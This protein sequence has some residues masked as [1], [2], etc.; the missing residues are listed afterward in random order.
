MLVAH[1]KKLTVEVEEITPAQAKQVLAN[2]NTTNYRPLDERAAKAYSAVMARGEWV[3]NGEA[4]KFNG[5]EDLLDGQTRLRACVIA[6]KPFKTLV[7]RGLETD[8]SMDSGRPRTIA[9]VL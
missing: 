6:N 1:R 8:E 5:N 7:I 9:S 3:L 4:I 2:K